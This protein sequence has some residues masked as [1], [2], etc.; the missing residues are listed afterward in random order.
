MQT[1]LKHTQTILKRNL[2]NLLSLIFTLALL[3]A[4]AWSTPI[5]APDSSS[6]DR[7]RGYL[8]TDDANVAEPILICPVREKPGDSGGDPKFSRSKTWLS[9]N[10]TNASQVR[11]IAGKTPPPSSSGKPGDKIGSISRVY[12]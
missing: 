10:V 7:F 1:L 5:Q 9:Y 8:N 11:S 2:V 3:V 12:G 4:S 6:F